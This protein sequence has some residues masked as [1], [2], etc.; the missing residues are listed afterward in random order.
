MHVIATWAMIQHC[1]SRACSP[2]DFGVGWRRR[3]C[4]LRVRRLMSPSANVSVGPLDSRS[5]STDAIHDHKLSQDAQQLARVIVQKSACC[6]SRGSNTASFLLSSELYGASRA[7]HDCTSACSALIAARPH[8]QAGV[9]DMGAAR[10]GSV[11]SLRQRH[12]CQRILLPFP[13][14][15]KQEAGIRNTVLR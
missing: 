3:R 1:V 2:D 9:A 8:G 13:D 11:H 6:L 12:C 14:R 7:Y 15:C 5:C 10:S 4:G